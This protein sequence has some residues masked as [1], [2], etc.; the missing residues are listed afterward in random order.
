[1]RDSPSG[2]ADMAKPYL[3]AL[4]ERVVEAVLADPA[5]AGARHVRTLTSTILDGRCSSAIQNG[6]T[7]PTTRRLYTMHW[8]LR[9]GSNRKS[10]PRRG[11]SWDVWILSNQTSDS[12]RG[13]RVVL[14]G[15]RLIDKY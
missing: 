11:I 8:S 14:N 12:K 2:G 15:R 6:P 4:R 10:L 5:P 3:S 13:S 9:A 7:C 1:V